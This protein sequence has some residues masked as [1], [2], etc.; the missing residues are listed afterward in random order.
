MRTDEQIQT[1]IEELKAIAATPSFRK[2]S[3]F[4]DDNEAAI[5]AQVEVLEGRLTV[6][7]VD[8]REEIGDFTEHQYHSA[9][10]AANWLADDASTD[11]VAGWDGLH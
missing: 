7:D 5:E 9:Y 1:K 3:F 11:P 10:D 8:E 4:G 2:V 6:D